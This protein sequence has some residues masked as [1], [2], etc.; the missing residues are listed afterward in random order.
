M[1]TATLSS[2]EQKLCF[3][4]RNSKHGVIFLDII[5]SWQ[6]TDYGIILF[7][8]SKMIKRLV[9]PYIPTSLRPKDWKEVIETLVRQIEEL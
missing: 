7:T 8:L 9:N 4:A 5:D 1:Q 6:L 3:A 2:L